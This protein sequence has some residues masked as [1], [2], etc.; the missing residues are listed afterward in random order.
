MTLRSLARRP[1]LLAASGIACLLVLPTA[2]AGAQDAGYQKSCNRVSVTAATLEARWRRLDGSFQR[3]S[4]VLQGIENVDG[5][6]QLSEPG[7]PA[8]FRSSCRNIHVTGATL[9]ARCRPLDGAYHDTSV[10]VQ[11]LANID[12]TLR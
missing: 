3:T 2:P 12:G 4:V 5:Q 6:L 1:A 7:Q 11:G 10:V 8:A 9:S